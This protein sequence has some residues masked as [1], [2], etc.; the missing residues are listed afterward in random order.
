[1]KKLITTVLLVLFAQAAKAE[2]VYFLD[3]KLGD[4]VN[5]RK[6]IAT[7]EALQSC[8][9]YLIKN[10]DLKDLV[11]ERAISRDGKP[12]TVRYVFIPFVGDAFVGDGSH[13][14]TTTTTQYKATC[15]AICEEIGDSYKCEAYAVGKKIKSTTRSY[16][17]SYG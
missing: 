16:R 2:T 1:M 5:Q 4:G 8:Q 14:V 6:S 10:Y 13:K 12:S 17:A 15:E 7:R 9:E 11:F 3:F